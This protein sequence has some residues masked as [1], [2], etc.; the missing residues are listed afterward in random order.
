ML[1]TGILG[2][3]IMIITVTTTMS[4]HLPVSVKALRVTV[5]F[6]VGPFWMTGLVLKTQLP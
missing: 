1:K 5:P 4:Q 2:S 6:R 3:A